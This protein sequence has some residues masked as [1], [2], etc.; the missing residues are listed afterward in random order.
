MLGEMERNRHV[1]HETM[2]RNPC[3]DSKL[4]GIVRL[5]AALGR[6]DVPATGK[7]NLPPGE[8]DH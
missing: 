2:A 7:R 8:G 3:G 5:L 6:W 1:G 4:R